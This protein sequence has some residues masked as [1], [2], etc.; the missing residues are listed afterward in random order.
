LIPR[1]LMRLLTAPLQIS[2][3]P[4]I[5]TPVWIVLACLCWML[6][7]AALG[8]LLTI[9]GPLGARIVDLLGYPLAWLFRLCGLD[10]LAGVFS[11]GG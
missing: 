7:G 3:S 5:V 11:S 4:W 1:V 6:F 10:R 2:L 8:L 9:L